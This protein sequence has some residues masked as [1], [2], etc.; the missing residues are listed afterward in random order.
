[1]LQVVV[2]AREAFSVD[3]GSSMLDAAILVPPYD[4]DLNLATLECVVAFVEGY[5]V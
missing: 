3:F 5:N 4:V 1:M 2:D